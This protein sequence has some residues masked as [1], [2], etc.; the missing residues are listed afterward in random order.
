MKAPTNQKENDQQ[1]KRKNTVTDHKEKNNKLLL[2][3]L[4]CSALLKVREMQNNCSEIPI[5]TYWIPKV[6]EN[7]VFI[8]CCW[9]HKLVQSLGRIIW[10]YLSN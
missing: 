9:K 3:M 7:K 1:P 4:R 8:H 10:E 2:K 6:M 5:F